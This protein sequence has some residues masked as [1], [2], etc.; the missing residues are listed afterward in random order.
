MKEQL[1][2]DKLK[3]YSDS[4]YY[5]FH[6]PGHKRMSLSVGEPSLIDITEIPGFDDLHDPKGVILE[7]EQRAAALW[8]VN[9]T[10]FLIN[11]STGGILSA[12]SAAVP[13]GAGVLVAENC[14]KSVYHAC[15]LR[16]LKVS[17]LNPEKTRYGFPGRI[18]PEELLRGFRDYPDSKAVIVTSPTYE[19]ILSDIGSLSEIAHSHGAV[20]LVDEAHGAHL[21]FSE[22]LPRPAVRFGA[23]LVVESLHKTLPALN[24]TA[25]LHNVTGRIPDSEILRYLDIYET[26]SPSYVLLSSIDRCVDRLNWNRK[27]LFCSYLKRLREFYRSNR[28]LKTILVLTEEMLKKEEAFAKDPGKL[29]LIPKTEG[30]TGSMLSAR[31]REVYHLE[32]ER[33]EKDYVI[34]M[35]SV[36]DTE[37]GFHRLT[38]ALHEID[39]D[40]DGYA[41]ISLPENQSTLGYEIYR[42][43]PCSP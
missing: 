34:A 40:L 37:E 18:S 36:S 12:V 20:L 41:G 33:A 26:S 22:E 29:I 2:S 21:A 24:Q 3:A 5:P 8:G 9:R 4:D 32:T 42:G 25:L 27:E 10:F 23:D 43:F 35:T 19:G 31:L 38:E 15:F 39:K 14:H 28:D 6:M 17:P 30:V 16:D 11:G 1:L 13:K 7:A